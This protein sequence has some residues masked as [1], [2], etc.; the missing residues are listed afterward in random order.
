MPDPIST[1]RPPGSS[2]V[3]QLRPA[4]EGAGL[5]LPAGRGLRVLDRAQVRPGT[6]RGQDLVVAAPVKGCPGDV[7]HRP[8]A[9]AGALP[10][11]RLPAAIGRESHPLKATD[12][13]EEEMRLSG[14]PPGPRP[15]DRRPRRRRRPA[16]SRASPSRR[17]PRTRPAGARPR[18]RAG[19]GRRS[20]CPRASG[21][22]GASPVNGSRR[23]RRRSGGE[24]REGR[25]DKR[26]AAAEGEPAICASPFGGGMC[27]RRPEGSQLTPEPAG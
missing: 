7:G 21:G 8:E 20:P 27:P 23:L 16:P 11:R 14:A 9:D 25:G 4:R 13:A 17:W 12:L 3:G 26:Q 6:Q 5:E 22:R 1:T 24:R 18:S 19:A 10:A 2:P 15:W